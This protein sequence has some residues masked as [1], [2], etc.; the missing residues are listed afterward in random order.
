MSSVALLC[1]KHHRQIYRRLTAHVKKYMLKPSSHKLFLIDISSSDRLWRKSCN[2]VKYRSILIQHAICRPICGSV[3]MDVS[4]NAVVTSAIHL[5]W[6]S[7]LYDI[8]ISNN[9]MIRVGNNVRWQDMGSADS[10]KEEVVCGG[11]YDVDM[12]AWSHQAGQNKEL[13][14]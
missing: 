6:L 14:N 2:L 10:T 3:I 13:N 4:S 7:L 11:N 1:L 12:D 5:T 9:E 8:E